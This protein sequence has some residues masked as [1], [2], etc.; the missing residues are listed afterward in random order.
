MAQHNFTDAVSEAI[1]TAFQEA[2]KR[3]N[4]EV[5]DT[6]LLFGF[7]QDEEGYFSNILKSLKLSPQELLQKTNDF[8]DNLP[9][10][11]SPQEPQPSRSLQNRIQ[12]AELL[13]ADWQDSYVAA[14]H[15][16]LVF[17]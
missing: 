7:L 15:F 5:T 3:R 6:H 13:A 4:T 10:F 11:Q 1:Q 9:V 17:W 12:E 16:F 2:K 14:D 8:L